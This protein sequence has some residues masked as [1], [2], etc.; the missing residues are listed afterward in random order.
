MRY[1]ERHCGKAVIKD[2][3]LLAAAM[4]KLAWLEE[5]EEEGTLGIPKFGN[6]IP[7]E[8]RLPEDDRYILLSFENFSIPLVGRYY[9]D[10]TGAAFYVGDDTESCS[11]SDVFVNAWQPLPEPYQASHSQND[12]S[13]VI[14]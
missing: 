9:Q 8:E 4:E 14:A 5:L 7:V 6:W 12:E 11:S 10:E 1:T 2:K 13:E 3:A